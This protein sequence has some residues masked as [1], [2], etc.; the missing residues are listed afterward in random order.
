LGLGGILGVDWK[1]PLEGLLV[2]T[3]F[4]TPTP[5]EFT[6]KVNDGNDFNKLFSDGKKEN[7]DLPALGALGVRYDWEAL[8]VT[9][10]GTGYFLGLSKNG[11]YLK[12]YDDFGWET[13]LSAEYAFL[14]GLLK[15]SVGGMITKVGG[16]SK[17]YND[18]DFSLDSSSIGGGVVFTAIKDL[19][20]TLALSKTFYTD[21]SGQPS[22]TTNTT[23][24]KKDAFT[25]DV[26]VQYRM[27]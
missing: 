23:T 2:T 18:F 11:S 12:D 24:Y 6:T 1:T 26:G 27:F 7:K 14:P 9:A 10:S 25:I 20:L 16:N 8:S 19:D 3:R 17:T 5:L 22:G 13:G 15:A 21:G 4:E